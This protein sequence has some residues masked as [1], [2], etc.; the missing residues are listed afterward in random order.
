LAKKKTIV[1]PKGSTK[2]SGTIKNEDAAKKSAGTAKAKKGSAPKK[3]AP[4]KVA[5]ARATNILDHMNEMMDMLSSESAGD[6]MS[7]PDM[8]NT[9]MGGFDDLPTANNDAGN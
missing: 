1:A 2:G 7:E 6:A 5:K 3:K 8:R 4:V 9:P